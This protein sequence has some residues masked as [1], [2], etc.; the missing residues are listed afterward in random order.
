[1]WQLEGYQYDL[2]ADLMTAQV[3]RACPSGTEAEHA[4]LEVPLASIYED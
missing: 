1:M 3:V 2:T 4:D